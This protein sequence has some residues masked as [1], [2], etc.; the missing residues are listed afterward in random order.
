MLMNVEGAAEVGIEEVRGTTVIV[1]ETGTETEKGIEIENVDVIETE[2][3]T[4][5]EDI[6]AVEETDQMA[7]ILTGTGIEIEMI[8]G[9]R[10][11]TTTV[12]TGTLKIGSRGKS[13]QIATS[14]Y[15]PAQHIY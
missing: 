1:P 4:V 11:T 7:D 13:M 14:S 15:A 12:L 3:E 8:V 10:E 2:T 9:V 6:V 5:K